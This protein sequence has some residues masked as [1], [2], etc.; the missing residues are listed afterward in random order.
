M[1]RR[2]HSFA[3]YI[4]VAMFVSMSMSNAFAAAYWE[5]LPG[6]SGHGPSHHSQAGPV[7]SGHHDL[8]HSGHVHDHSR[9]DPDARR[10]CL[11]KCAQ[12]APDECLVT[13]SAKVLK[14]KLLG[15]DPVDALA[16]WQPTQLVPVIAQLR[17]HGPPNCNGLNFAS[18]LHGL[19]LLN[20]RLRN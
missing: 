11:K 5:P 13:T 15:A 6:Q 19:L 16:V 10:S 7:Q 14:R 2:L 4:L 12:A 17:D 18:G 1:Q 8:S 9:I 20:S 3:V